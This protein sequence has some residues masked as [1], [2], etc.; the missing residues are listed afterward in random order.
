MASFIYGRTA[1][2]AVTDATYAW[3]ANLADWRCALV[4][5]EYDPNNLQQEPEFQTH[6]NWDDHGAAY[7]LDIKPAAARLVPSLEDSADHDFRNDAKLE[8][9]FAQK[10]WINTTLSS[11]AKGAIY[12]NDTSRAM[13]AFVDFGGAI[14]FAAS[15]TYTISELTI[16]FNL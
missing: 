8:I 13:A 1:S 3:S 9:V 6:W 15:K 14:V 2:L 10:I 12:Y 5:T 4:S 16:S 7:A 11:A